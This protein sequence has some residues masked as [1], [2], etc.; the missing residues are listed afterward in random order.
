MRRFGSRFN[1]R[2]S[3]LEG[4]VTFGM[5]EPG[6]NPSDLRIPN[7]EPNRVPGT[8]KREV[9]YALG[10]ASLTAGATS[11]SNVLKFSTNIPASFFACSSYLPASGQVLRGSSTPSGTPGQVVGTS[12]L[13]T[14][15]F[16]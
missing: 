16:V 8:R 13:K 4:R 14:G 5:R 10:P 12:M 1:A 9:P 6:A 2:G 11:F 7:S 3:R 15:C